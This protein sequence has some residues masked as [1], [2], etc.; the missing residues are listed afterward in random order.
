MLNEADLCRLSDETPNFGKMIE[1]FHL[2]QCVE[3]LQDFIE[4]T[5]LLSLFDEKSLRN[6]EV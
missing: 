3:H 5:L 1:G 2:S 6:N 4:G